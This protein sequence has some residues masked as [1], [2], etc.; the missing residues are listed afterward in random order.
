MSF[1][2]VSLVCSQNCQKVSKSYVVE[3]KSQTFLQLIDFVKE[4]NPDS[5][6]V[7]DKNV[8]IYACSGAGPF[9]SVNFLM[10]F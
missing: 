4:K 1:V 8:F 10:L 6:F 2:K 3:V 7:Q 9:I 5:R